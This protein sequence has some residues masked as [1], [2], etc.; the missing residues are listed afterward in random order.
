MTTAPIQASSSASHNPEDLASMRL[1]YNYASL[2]E[3]SVSPNPFTQFTRWF[4]EVKSLHTEKEPNAMC[5]S[6][7]S[8]EGRPSARMVLLKDMDEKGYEEHMK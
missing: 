5:L 6:T 3:D 7:T 2:T 4:D 8:K 1:T